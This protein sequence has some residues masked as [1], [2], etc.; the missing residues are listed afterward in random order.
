YGYELVDNSNYWFDAPQ[1][2]GY[3][4]Q[5]YINGI[6][7]N[8]K[9]YAR[10]RISTFSVTF[11][12]YYYPYDDNGNADALSV[13]KPLPAVTYDKDE[14]GNDLTTGYLRMDAIYF[15]SFAHA[16]NLSEIYFGGD[17][18]YENKI[19][20]EQYE[21]DV[22][23]YNA[24]WAEKNIIKAD[25]A[26]YEGY[27]KEIQDYE[28]AKLAYT[29]TPEAYERYAVLKPN[30]QLYRKRLYDAV[31]K[32][33][34][35]NAYKIHY[36]EEGEPMPTGAEAGDENVA[37][38]ARER[39]YL[40][41][42]YGAKDVNGNYILEDGKYVLQKDINGD[43]VD[44]GDY[45]RYIDLFYS[46]DGRDGFEFDGWYTS[47]NFNVTTRVSSL[48]D[49][50]TPSFDVE[51]NII[52]YAKWVDLEKGSDGLVFE[53][54]RESNPEYT[55]E[56]GEDEFIYYFQVIDYLSIDQWNANYTTVYEGEQ[57]YYQF[58]DSTIGMTRRVLS[59]NIGYNPMPASAV[60]LD[61]SVKIPATHQSQ[62]SQVRRLS[63]MLF[64]ENSGTVMSVDIPSTITEIEEGALS[65]C[66]MLE[67]ITLS[68][69]N[70]SLMI[71][72]GVLYSADGTVL[73]CHPARMQIAEYL[74]LGTIV[75]SSTFIVGGDVER[76]AKGAFIGCGHLKYIAFV[77]SES[78]LVI[79]EDAFKGLGGL[80]KV[81]NPFIVTRLN[82]QT[83]EEENIYV[84]DHILPDRLV[85]IESR[86]FQ[87]C[88]GITNITTSRQ[89]QLIY[90][91]TSVLDGSSWYHNRVVENC[92][93]LDGTSSDGIIM[94][95]FV[96]LGTASDFTG[97]SIILNET[98]VKSIADF[99]FINKT[100][101]VDIKLLNT[102]S[103]YIG[104][105]AF[106]NC[107]RL[108][109]FEMH[110]MDPAICRLGAAAF[111][112][113]G[114][115]DFTIYV[116]SASNVAQAYRD[117]AGWVAYASKIQAG[118]Y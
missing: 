22:A 117:A 1:D 50:F 59:E 109:S 96:A 81:G 17:D 54:L 56:N 52:L 102:N 79:G 89:S 72:K 64:S 76:I 27:I 99:A 28:I 103:R 31:Q 66:F 26:R 9:F 82:E 29:T 12:D 5:I 2:A 45:Q 77:D 112:G 114:S 3:A 116:P 95:G 107:S 104:E 41:L 110:N 105:S 87:N 92:T 32:Q 53:K 39:E 113:A 36:Y 65:S 60:N 62:Y 101:L 90:V 14:F 85:E 106:L 78:E 30:H 67:L 74:Y 33:D 37:T 93:Y 108:T 15:R 42:R 48:D 98:E 84:S 111:Q 20:I 8:T 73:I 34:F 23:L 6:T 19:F 47:P 46:N 18:V 100:G 115:V 94:L 43:Y 4:M 16:F 40:R 25:I 75:P 38:G 44:N 86:A 61:A 49:E 58:F 10:Y 97:T 83:E 7:A 57:T 91:G 69:D 13:V 35:I 55:P 118:S 70:V 51:N 24:Y 88:Y 68:D 71:D 11:R 21:A 80:L 63:A